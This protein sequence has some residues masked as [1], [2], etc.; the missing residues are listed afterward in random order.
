MADF[1]SLGLDPMLVR[2]V[3]KLGFQQPTPVQSRCI[4]K[5]LEG[6]DVLARAPTGSG[7]TLAYAAPLVHKVLDHKEAGTIGALVLVPTRELCNQVH[8]VVTSLLT[9]VGTPIR[10]NH[11]AGDEPIQSQRNRLTPALLPQILVATPARLLQHLTH[12][13]FQLVQGHLHTLVLDEA[14]LVL[15]Y[16]YLADML[17]V[18]VAECLRPGRLLPTHPCTAGQIGAHV[19]QGVQAVLISATLSPD[20]DRVKELFLH[21]PI[22]VDLATTSAGGAPAAEGGDAAMPVDK[23]SQYWTSCKLK[24][25]FLL[26]FALLKLNRIPGKALVFCNDVNRAFRLKLFLEQFGVHCGVLNAELPLNSRWH[27]IQAFNKG[28]FDFLIAADDPLIHAGRSGPGTGTGEGDGAAP[29]R[30]KKQRKSNGEAA[31]GAADA[32]EFGPSRGVDF[33]GVTAVIN[34]DLPTTV[35]AYK[36]RVGR[37]ARGNL[38]GSSISLAGTD[39]PVEMGF[40]DLLRREL[41]DALQALNVDFAKLNSFRYRV[42]DALRAVTRAAVQEAR[43]KD[44]RAEMLNS[45][46]LKAHFQRFPEDLLALQHDKPLKTVRPAPALKRIP[47]YLAPD[48][49]DVVDA[50]VTDRMKAVASAARRPK[51]GKKKGRGGSSE[52]KKK[53]TQKRDPLRSGGKRRR[54]S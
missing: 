43:L 13:H 38:D 2:A 9:Y 37:T 14:D 3:G 7:K 47:K 12:G 52:R 40:V 26:V 48:R 36:H 54:T 11:A 34:F 30:K 1:G 49:R 21:N 51:R 33:T 10:V 46:R 39:D 4:P 5:I 42:D 41:G 45:E 28:A 18:C 8:D 15:S 16:G 32:V 22:V 27:M 53:Q 25:K 35:S 24:D 31:E 6:H 17:K 50:E 20:M 44:V 23:L 29:P 19:P